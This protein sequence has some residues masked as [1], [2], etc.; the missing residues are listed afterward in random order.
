FRSVD[1]HD[2][3][4]SPPVA[5]DNAVAAV[6]TGDRLPGT[7][8]GRL[9]FERTDVYIPGIGLITAAPTRLFDGRLVVI[10]RGGVMCVISGG[11][12]RNQPDQHKGYI[13]NAIERWIDRL[14]RRLLHTFVRGERERVCGVRREHHVAGYPS[15]LDVWRRICASHR[16]LRLCIRHDD[17]W[18]VRI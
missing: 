6:G 15:I 17:A 9:K 16:S 1:N 10:D 18:F 2:R 8:D 13:P 5:L 4:S 14:R 3:L 11:R 12:T 7:N